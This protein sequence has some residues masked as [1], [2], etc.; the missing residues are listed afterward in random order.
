MPKCPQCN[1]D[2]P[3]CSFYMR[4]KHGRLHSWCKNCFNTKK[5]QHWNKLKTMAVEYLGGK[6]LDCGYVGHPVAYDFHHRDPSVK[7]FQWNVL[8][9]KSWNKIMTELHKCDLLCCICHRL[10]HINTHNWPNK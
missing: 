7:E 2:L 10:R 1:N 6:C 4:G 9:K 5:M 3:V 8:R